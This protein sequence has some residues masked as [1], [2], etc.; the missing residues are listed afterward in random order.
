MQGWELDAQA[1]VLQWA[2]DGRRREESRNRSIRRGGE[3]RVLVRG[4]G[5]RMRREARSRKRIRRRNCR[6]MTREKE[7]KEKNEMRNRKRTD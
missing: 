3:G 4:K 5:I 1:L 2:P 7:R 6:E